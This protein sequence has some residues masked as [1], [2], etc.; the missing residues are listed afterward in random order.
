M[1]ILFAPSHYML[2]GISGS[3]EYGWAY[4]IVDTLSTYP[5]VKLFVLTGVVKGEE[6]FAPNVTVVRL[7]RSPTLNL[8]FSYR[9][10]FIARYYAAARQVLRHHRIDLIH[11]I[12]PFGHGT[13][14]NPLPLL[15]QT[16]AIPLVIGPLQ[17]PHTMPSAE[18]RIYSQGDVRQYRGIGD[19]LQEKGGAMLLHRGGKIVNMLSAETLRR[20]DYLVAV[21]E[22]ARQLYTAQAPH[23]PS[24]VI[25]PGLPLER[26]EGIATRRQA[27]AVLEILYVGWLIQRKGVDLIIDAIADLVVQFPLLRLRIVGDGPQRGALE[28]LVERRGLD[29]HVIFEG[30]VPGTKV[31]E[32]YARADVFVSMSYSE[33]FGQSLVEAMVM[34][35]PVI[36][37]ENVGSRE[38]VQ[39][40]VTGYLVTPGVTGE[41]VARLRLLLVDSHLRTMVGEQARQT[42]R[43]RYNWRTI[44]QQY[45]NVYREAIQRRQTRLLH[46]SS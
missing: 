12:L 27:G 11:H 19:F 16:G 6:A 40:G 30:V 25:A 28:D 39:D 44:G 23:V 3:S 42:A 35:L 1:N 20:S 45:L 15:G 5:N 22:Q 10:A 43:Q 33:S 26:F 24:T 36:S 29:R 17:A 4:H 31:G 32:Y 14:F 38:I 41:L 9:L 2:D 8:T 13:T 46:V 21:N 18:E 37:A 34:G 7:D